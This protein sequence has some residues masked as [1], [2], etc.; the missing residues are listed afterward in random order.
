MSEEK[1]KTVDVKEKKKAM[2]PKTKKIIMFS[3]IG[4]V[5]LI[6]IIAAII[7]LVNISGKPSK[8]KAESLVKDYLKAVNDDDDEKFAKLIDVKGY[9]IFKE[10]EEKKFDKKYKE[11]ED[12]IKDYLKDNDYDDLSEAKDTI[13]R[14]FKSKYSYSSYEYSIKEITEVKKSNK[15]KKISIIKAK[16][17][18]KSSYSSLSDTKNLKLYVI[19]ADGGYKIVGAEL[20]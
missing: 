19:K 2:S 13:T 1:V 17:K 10:E 4:A 18:A 5:A 6:L 7:V 16:V 9:I 14:N 8:S 15:S 12:Y 20:E 3:A 11:K